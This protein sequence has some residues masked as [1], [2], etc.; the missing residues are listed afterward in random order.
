[1]AVKEP[2]GIDFTTLAEANSQEKGS[3]SLVK[4]P[5]GFF[6]RAVSYIKASFAEIENSLSDGG[7]PD[8][9]AIRRSGENQR[10]R[11]IL[12][13]LYN[14]RE[15][16]VV[17]AALN[18]SRGIDQRT[19]NMTENEK[20]LFFNL[21]VEIENK[22]DR[23]L[24]YDRLLSRPIVPRKETGIDTMTDDFSVEDRVQA[25]ARNARAKVIEPSDSC[26]LPR[27]VE[28]DAQRKGEAVQE[29][30]GAC[31]RDQ[32]LVKALVDVGPFA[33][34]DGSSVQMSRNDIATI[35]RSIAEILVKQG[36]ARMMEGGA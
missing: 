15:R 25:A 7:V 21:K 17:L 26:E 31:L 5:E 22:R 10:A 13:S 18:S 32:K 28:A 24:R 20:D 14:T 27:K 19:E 34:G 1:M 16:K 12:E 3:N 35:P 4:L 9:A 29:I 36:M 33:C 6:E 8:K 30:S 2:L 11:E 23:V